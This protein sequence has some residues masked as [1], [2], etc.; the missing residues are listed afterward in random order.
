MNENLNITEKELIGIYLVLRENQNSFDNTMNRLYNEIEKRIQ[1][2]MTID[3]FERIREIY[4]QK[5]D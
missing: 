5:A 4:E 2:S 1:N 3:Q